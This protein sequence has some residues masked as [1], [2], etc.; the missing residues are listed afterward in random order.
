MEQVVHRIV[1]DRSGF[2]SRGKHVT[3]RHPMFFLPARERETVITVDRRRAC[4]AFPAITVPCSSA[5]HHAADQ[6]RERSVS[7]FANGSASE[8]F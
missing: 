5:G 2:V 6:S 1:R 4:G 3:M 7:H 8:N